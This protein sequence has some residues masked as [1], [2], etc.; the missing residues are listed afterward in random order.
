MNHQLIYF[1]KTIKEK[2]TWINYLLRNEITKLVKHRYI[3]IK[4]GDGHI[5]LFLEKNINDI[6]NEQNTLNGLS[7]I[8]ANI[9]C[10]VCLFWVRFQ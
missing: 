1:F 5:M 6:R 9:F 4:V 10:L 3:F 7:L 8:V 2:S